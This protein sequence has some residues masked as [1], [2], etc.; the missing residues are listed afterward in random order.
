M[1]S[2]TASK[3][4]PEPAQI[5]TAPN[6]ARLLR[7]ILS[8]NWALLPILILLCAFAFYVEK[9]V[10]H[11]GTQ[12]GFLIG[13]SRSPV[14]GSVTPLIF[15]LLGAGV[16]AAI[17]ELT[18]ESEFFVGLRSLKSLADLTEDQ[19]KKVRFESAQRLIIK[20]LAACYAMRLI[21]MF[22]Y[23][24][25]HG[26]YQGQRLQAIEAKRPA[27]VQVAPLGQI[28]VPDSKG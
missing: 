17:K 13:A 3:A 24:T 26:I 27:A 11:A 19:L 25:N 12:F 1:H 16:L 14:S 18:T 5:Q 22:V 8:D 2:N 6:P 21:V 20:L 10:L 15:G 9:A 7:S 4:I 28:V 23:F